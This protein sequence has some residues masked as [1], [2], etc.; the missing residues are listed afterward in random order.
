MPG[1][2]R[3]IFTSGATESANLA[4]FSAVGGFNV[5][6]GGNKRPRHVIVGAAEHPAV[7]Q[8]LSNYVNLFRRSGQTLEITEMSPFAAPEDY[9]RNVTENTV[10]CALMSVNNENGFAFDLPGIYQAVKRQNPKT[11]FFCDHAQ[12]FLRTNPIGDM[13]GISAHKI[14][15]YKGIGALCMKSGVNIKP[16]LFGGGQ[17]KNL[18]PGTLPTE[19]IAAFGAAVRDY[20]YDRDRFAE[21]A[22]LLIQDLSRE[23]ESGKIILNGYGG[24]EGEISRGCLPHIL[25]LAVLSKPAEVTVNYLSG[26]GIFV[27]GGAAC[28]KGDKRRSTLK[29]FNIPE[30]RIA[31]A[32]RVSFSAGNTAADVTGLCEALRAFV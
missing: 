18:R 27:S 8:T 2:D 7:A 21:L 15:G 29:A 14:H 16:M 26:K 3:V 1:F 5:G 13:I 19:L 24:N 25:N 28:S 9:A 10:L 6:G 17:Q 4:I 12:G 11:L 30:K 31:T 20:R 22:D 32:I 23:I